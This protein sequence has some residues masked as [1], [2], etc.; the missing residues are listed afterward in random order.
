MWRSIGEMFSPESI[1]IPHR[2]EESQFVVNWEVLHASRAAAQARAEAGSGAQ[3]EGWGYAPWRALAPIRCSNLAD[4]YCE[5]R[6]LWDWAL[7]SSR[8]NSV[9]I[10]G[11][12]SCG[13]SSPSPSVFETMLLVIAIV[14]VP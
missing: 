1:T 6:Q 14:M 2:R 7:P 4:T 3:L 9:A 12:P 13:T 10:R 11:S 8:P 5:V